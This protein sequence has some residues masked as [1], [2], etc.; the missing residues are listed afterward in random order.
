MVS[1]PV[2]GDVGGLLGAT[3]FVP[4]PTE[5]QEPVLCQLPLSF[6][7]DAQNG[8]FVRKEPGLQGEETV[9]LSPLEM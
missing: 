7:A 1:T 8:V 3:S 5:L 9:Q 6:P 2:A 4:F